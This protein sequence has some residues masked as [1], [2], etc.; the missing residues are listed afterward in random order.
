MRLIN[1]V[2]THVWA[3][4]QCVAAGI[5]AVDLEVDPVGGIAAGLAGQA[6]AR[7]DTAEARSLAF[8]AKTELP[9]DFL[10]TDLSN[11]RHS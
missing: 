1:L 11:R 6:A 3:A 10:D 7:L 9:P 2:E 5:A 8:R 4:R